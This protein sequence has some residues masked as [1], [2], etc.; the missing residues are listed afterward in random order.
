MNRVLLAAVAVALAGCGMTDAGSFLIDPGRYSVY[1]CDELATRWTALVAR[2]NELHGLIDKAGESG[3]GGR[4]HRF[5]RLSDRLR[6]R[7]QRGEAAAAH[8][9]RKKLRLQACASER[10]DH[11]LTGHAGY[12]WNDWAPP[13]RSKKADGKR[14]RDTR[15]GEGHK[16]DRTPGGRLAA[17]KTRGIKRLEHVVGGG[18]NK[19]G[20]RK[21]AIRHAGYAALRQIEDERIDVGNADDG[22][23]RVDA[24]NAKLRFGDCGDD[25]NRDKKPGEYGSGA[26]RERIAARCEM[27]RGRRRLLSAGLPN[28]YCHRQI[29]KPASDRPESGSASERASGRLKIATTARMRRYMMAV[30]SVMPACA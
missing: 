12:L 13:K 18:G 27:H 28:R 21:C 1:H 20:G 22:G 11:P 2:E 5:A 23:Q 3:A 7:A 8:G 16:R 19:D 25:R 6:F 14:G 4:R 9:G 30:A 26:E 29:R 24:G 10:P 17:G 15:R